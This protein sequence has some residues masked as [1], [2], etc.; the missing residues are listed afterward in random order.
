MSTRSAPLAL[1]LLAACGAGGER[2]YRESAARTAG[3]A[4]SE[5]RTVEAAARG[6]LAGDLTAAYAS[7]VVLASDAALGPVT[8][9]FAGTD[10]PTRDQD[11]LRAGVLEDLSSAQDAVATARTALARGDDAGLRSAVEL[12]VRAGEELEQDLEA[13]R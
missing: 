11:E 6:Y 1:L 9:S 8:E 10:P 13:L 5:T 12:L 7:T 3:S 4:L 2:G